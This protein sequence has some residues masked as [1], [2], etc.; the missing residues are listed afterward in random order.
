[1][2]ALGKEPLLQS[3]NPVGA[4]KYDSDEVFLA[5]NSAGEIDL[6]EK[7]SLPEHTA[8]LNKAVSAY[9]SGDRATAMQIF[10]SLSL[11]PDVSLGI[12]QEAQVYIAEILYVQGD[13]EGA[14]RFFERLIK[15]DPSYRIDRFRHP[16]DVCGYFDFVKSYLAT[17]LEQSALPAPSVPSFPIFGYAPFGVYFL[18]QESPNSG[19]KLLY[20]FGETVLLTTSTVL[21]ISLMRDHSHFDNDLDKKAQLENRMLWQR[22]TTVAFYTLWAINIIDSQRQW[23]LSLRENET[24]ENGTENKV[25]K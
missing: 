3:T 16:P 25:I 9:Q 17:E 18:K 11:Q 14:Q 22:S 24:T 20:T 6:P 21:F 8:E 5:D 12:R 1:M 10:L 13:K 4:Q 7:T 23:Q 2:G 19:R 15:E